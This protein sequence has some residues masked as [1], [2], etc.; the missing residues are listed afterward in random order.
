M[1]YK[2][3][4]NRI[5]KMVN[6]GQSFSQKEVTQ[7]KDVNNLSRFLLISSPAVQQADHLTLMQ[8][9]AIRTKLPLPLKLKSTL[10]SFRTIS[11]KSVMPEQAQQKK[12]A[13]ARNAE[14][15]RTVR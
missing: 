9:Q 12:H 11:F 7:P 10:K 4:A 3:Y 6:L 15:Y 1:D 13:Q 2:K 14:H 8:N 5:D